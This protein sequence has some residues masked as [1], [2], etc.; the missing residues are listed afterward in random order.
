M[1]KERRNLRLKPDWKR[2]GIG[3]GTGVLVMLVLAAA[4]AGLVSREA[5]AVGAM[6]WTAAVVLVASAFA[7]AKMAGQPLDAALAALGEW[8]VLFAINAALFGGEMEG[9]GVT[10]LALAGGCGAALLLGRGG[11][12]HR[13][14]PRSRRKNR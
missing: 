3:T 4:V 11:K 13:R 14:R 7:G 12:K 8:V 1:N 6:G 2:V 9:I 5:L 10:F